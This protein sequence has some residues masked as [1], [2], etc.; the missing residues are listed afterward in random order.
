MNKK[1]FNDIK[2]ELGSNVKGCKIVYKFWSLVEMLLMLMC[3]KQIIYPEIDPYQCESENCDSF[4]ESLHVAELI[5]CSTVDHIWH[6]YRFL[7]FAFFLHFFTH[8]K[9]S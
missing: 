5:K 2:I 9:L 8:K 6:C 3:H 1:E 7:Q 4:C